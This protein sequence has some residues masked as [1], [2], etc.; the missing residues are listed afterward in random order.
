[1]TNL[2]AEADCTDCDGG[3]YCGAKGQDQPHSMEYIVVLTI[4]VLKYYSGS[5]STYWAALCILLIQLEIW[6]FGLI[7]ICPSLNMSV[8]FAKVS[9]F[10]IDT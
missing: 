4:L 6:V 5:Q 8:Q 3:M 7:Q 9:L 2:Q 1:M 10:I